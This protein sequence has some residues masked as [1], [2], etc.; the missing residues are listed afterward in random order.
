[1]SLSR[2]L[3]RVSPL[4]SLR[5][6]RLV[7]LLGGTTTLADCVVA[8]RYALTGHQ[9]IE[10]PALKAYEQA[11][12]EIIGVRHA[13]SFA[14]GRVGLFG[15][16]R[17]LAVGPGDAVVL[18]VPTHVVVANAIRY[19][20]AR[21]AYVDCDP[22][23]YN[24]DLA[25]A[26]ASMPKDAKVL[27][28]QHTFGVPV[29]LDAALAL[30]ER[31]RLAL[32]EDCVHSLGSMY[33][34]RPV[35]SFGRASFFSTEETKTITSTLGG[36]VVTDDPELAERIRSFQTQCRPPGRSTTIAR[37]LKFVLYHVQT[38]PLVHRSVRGAYLTMGR[39]NPLPAATLPDELEGR[40]PP[41]Y[42]ERLSNAQAALA[43]RQLRRLQANIHHR[44]SIAAIYRGG[45]EAAGAGVP[46]EP[47]GSEPVYVRY[48]VKVSDRSAAYRAALAT[49][50]VGDWFTSVL[51]ESSSAD[52]GGYEAGSCPRAEALSKTLINLPTH[53]GVQAS[54]ARATISALG[55]ASCLL[56]D[57]TGPP[58]A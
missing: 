53:P 45:L 55:A 56:T 8:L 23:T 44:R 4:R 32:V 46:L 42:E 57:P 27:L 14:T 54:D 50:V 51:E 58:S 26:E 40:R 41:G 2:G 30:A 16:L 52:V 21:P 38:H 22:R 9:L 5:R 19:T 47:P 49:M 18:Q 37:L 24:I 34:G 35:G 43:L 31:H 20:G 15:L 36:M 39:R 28:L 17:A 29:D 6:L 3:L 12:A 25:L 1:V 13:F 10:G 48:P 11:F 33:G 7:A